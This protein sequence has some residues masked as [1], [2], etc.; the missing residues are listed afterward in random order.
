M[1]VE[2]CYSLHAT[3]ADASQN[4]VAYQNSGQSECW[5][6]VDGLPESMSVS[7]I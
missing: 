5:V 1:K 6:A 4:T 7:V 3:I 2:F